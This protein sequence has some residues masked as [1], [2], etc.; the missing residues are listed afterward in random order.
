L[1]LHK[2][3]ALSVFEPVRCFYPL[4]NR[5]P[6]ISEP[7]SHEPL[8]EPF[9]RSVLIAGATTLLEDIQALY[10]RRESLEDECGPLLDEFARTDPIPHFQAALSKYFAYLGAAP[11]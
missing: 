1:N 5:V 8:T 4:I 2:S 3:D 11:N 6:V 7:F 10:A 9:E